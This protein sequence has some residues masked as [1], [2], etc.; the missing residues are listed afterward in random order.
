MDA[1]IKFLRKKCMI[2]PKLKIKGIFSSIALVFICAM[3]F[4][5]QGCTNSEFVFFIQLSQDRSN[6]DSPLSLAFQSY[7]QFCAIAELEVHTSKKSFL[8]SVFHCFNT[9]AGAKNQFSV[10]LEGKTQYV[11]NKMQDWFVSDNNSVNFFQLYDQPTEEIRYVTFKGLKK[12]YLVDAE[13]HEAKRSIPFD[14]IHS[15][16]HKPGLRAIELTFKP[17]DEEYDINRLAVNLQIE[18][19][20]LQQTIDCQDL[21]ALSSEVYNFFFKASGGTISCSYGEQ[22]WTLSKQ[23]ST[24]ILM[25]QDPL[26]NHWYYARLNHLSGNFTNSGICNRNNW[27]GF[28]PVTLKEWSSLKN[29]HLLNM[30]QTIWGPFTYDSQQFIISTRNKQDIPI[31]FNHSFKELMNSKLDEESFN[32]YT[33]CVA[34]AAPGPALRKNESTLPATDESIPTLTNTSPFM[35]LKHPA[36]ISLSKTSSGF[37]ANNP[38]TLFQKILQSM[39]WVRTILNVSIEKSNQSNQVKPYRL[40]VTT[41]PSTALQKSE[42]HTFLFSTLRQA[43][44]YQTAINAGAHLDISTCVSQYHRFS[45]SLHPSTFLCKPGRDIRLL[46]KT[47]AS[48]HDQNLKEQ[49]RKLQEKSDLTDEPLEFLYRIASSSESIEELSM[50]SK[51]VESTD[52]EKD[53]LHEILIKRPNYRYFSLD[54]DP[55]SL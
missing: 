48:D 42:V 24:N 44:R 53:I 33:F 20:P 35:I 14:L 49:I 54:E 19:F 46:K 17:L 1:C 38:K 52:A 21:S 30:F 51:T 22:Q 4:L 39:G 11:H 43:K 27:T 16:K 12:L 8:T 15:K 31:L 45:N 40:L 5:A 32:Y 18:D 47:I 13:Y 25:I 26:G 36:P 50:N 37:D 29:Q 28:K 3:S 10:S 2:S 9:E 55:F 7:K 34:E 23:D 41:G 6:V